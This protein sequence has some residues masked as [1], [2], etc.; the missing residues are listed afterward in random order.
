MTIRVEATRNALADEYA[1][2]AVKL[3]LWSGDPAG[4]GSECTGTSYARQAITWGAAASST[5]SGAE[6]TFE[7]PAGTWDYG[8][9]HDASGTIVDSGTIT[10]TILNADGQ[11]KVTPTY[12]QA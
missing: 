4:S 2:R 7:A 10:T 8:A 5:V 3:S 11:V 12:T 6:V 9:L 1:S